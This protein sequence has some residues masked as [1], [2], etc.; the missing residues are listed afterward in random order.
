MDVAEVWVDNR[1]VQE[2]DGVHLNRD[3]Y[4]LLTRAVAEGVSRYWWIR[5]S[6][7]NSSIAHS[8]LAVT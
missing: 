8:T 5:Q 4:A 2:V 6:S 3:G 7:A 1:N